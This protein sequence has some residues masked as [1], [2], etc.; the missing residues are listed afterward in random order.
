MSILSERMSAPRRE[1]IAKNPIPWY[2]PRF[3][4]GMRF[5]TWMGHWARNHFAVS[6][7][8]LPSALSITAVTALNSGLAA[9]DHLLYRRRVA[10]VEISQSPLF[11]LG[12]WR[13]G[14]TFLH[15]L[16]IRDPEHTFPSTYQCFVP[17]HFVFTD[18]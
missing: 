18:A 17:H 10:Q 16:L 11:I 13:S 15:E 2:A 7:S 3:W 9:I 6:L 14:T 5:S 1:R 4:H 12:H 8:K